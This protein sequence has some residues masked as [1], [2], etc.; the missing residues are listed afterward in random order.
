MAINYQ[1]IHAAVKAKILAATGGFRYVPADKAVNIELGIYPAGLRNKGFNVRLTDQDES[2]FEDADRFRT[3]WEIQFTLNAKSD[4]YLTQ[5]ANAVS[6]VASLRAFTSTDFGTYRGADIFEHIWESTPLG[7]LMLV[8]FSEI[9]IE[10][11][12]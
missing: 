6:A 10:I 8:T 9:Y 11:E 3:K 4:T 1:T 7:A 2:K 5:L 12:G